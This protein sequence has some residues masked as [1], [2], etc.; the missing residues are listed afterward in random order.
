MHQ[1]FISN[2]YIFYNIKNLLYL[3]LLI[4]YIL[5]MYE[6]SKRVY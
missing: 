5:Y 2:T 6:Y 4:L 1:N 3:Y